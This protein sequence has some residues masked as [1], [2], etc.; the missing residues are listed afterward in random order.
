MWNDQTG[1]SHR[2]TSKFGVLLLIYFNI[3]N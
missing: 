3:K 1:L 2:N